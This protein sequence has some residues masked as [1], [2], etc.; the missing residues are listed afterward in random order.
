M[1]M[2]ICTACGI[3][4]PVRA[5]CPVCEDERQ[6]VPE[7][8]QHWTDAKDLADTHRTLWREEA[9]GVHSLITEPKFAIGQRAFLIEH[10]EGNVL[11]DCVTLLDD[12]THARIDAMGGL[13]AIAISHPHYYSAMA[14]WARAFDAP[15]HVHADD[16]RWVQ[17]PSDRIAFWEG[18]THPLAPDLTLIRCGGHF[19]GAAVL[20]A[21]HLDALFP[22]DTIQVV[23]DR[24]HVSFMRSYP[25]LIPLNAGTVR[26][27]VASVEPLEFDAIYGAFPERTIPSDG[28]QAVRRSAERYIAAISDGGAP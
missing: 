2:R 9:P 6:F 13:R 22:G 11:W 20:H 21:D 25:N 16:A 27:I 7:G 28:K 1:A 4:Q 23:P 8:G 15:V 3:Q 19:S 5:Q 24:R 18:E 12:A 14:A 17:E 10:P 26:R